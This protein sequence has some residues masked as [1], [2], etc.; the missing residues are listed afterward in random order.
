MA[1]PL[2]VT[3]LTQPYPKKD[4]HGFV[5]LVSSSNLVIVYQTKET[6][7]CCEGISIVLL[8]VCIITHIW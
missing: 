7:L 1:D 2:G 6:W 8:Y 3:H 5:I 4:I